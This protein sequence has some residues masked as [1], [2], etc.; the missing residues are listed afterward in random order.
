MF[1]PTGEPAVDRYIE[2]GYETVRGMSSQFAAS[3][4][5]AILKHQASLG[6]SGHFA[7][8]GTFEGRF[9]IAM[10]LALEPGEI[11]LGID[12]FDW[13]NDRVMDLFLSHCARHGVAA[14]RFVALKRDSRTMAPAEVASALGGGPVRFFHID[15]EHGDEA[16]SK[17]LALA[18]PL[19][20]PQGLIC[21]D[22]MLHPGYPR[23]VDTVHRWLDANRE[24]QVLAI[25]DREDIVA[26][27]KYILCRRDAV[28]LYEQPL[29]ERFERNV[30]ILGGDFID[31]VSV[32][33]TPFPRLAEVD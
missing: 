11:A 17:D 25:L 19:M 4:C 1:I 3:I 27:G 33:L 31:H 29:L 7:E 8:I 13:P 20:H 26:A 22:D 14:D 2:Q 30:F 9:F 10:A 5:A 12:L 28:A 24:W 32:V 21:L 16:L 6:I 15:G 23:L 18:L